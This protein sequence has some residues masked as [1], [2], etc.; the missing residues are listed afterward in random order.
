M[1]LLLHNK[2]YFVLKMNL[3]TGFYILLATLSLTGLF[4]CLGSDETEYIYSTDAQLTSFSLSHDSLAVLAKAKFSIDQK[5]SL[6]YNYDSLPY[7]TDTAAIASQAIVKYTAGSGSSPSLRIKHL[8]GDTAWVASGDTLRFAS[9]FEIKLYSPSGN[10]KTYTVSISIH[11]L[12]PD[13]VQ[14]RRVYISDIPAVTTPDWPTLSQHCPDTLKVVAC[15]GFLRPDEQKDLTLIVKDKNDLRFAFSKN[16]V[17]YQLGEKIPEGFPI[18]GFT[19]FNDRSFAGRLTVISSM[20][21]VW[22]TENGLYWT[23]LFGTQGLLPVIE[24]GNAFFYNNEIWFVN[25]KTASGEYNSKIYFSRDG[26]IVW[27]EKPEKTLP[28]VEFPL[29]QDATLVV[30]AEGKYYYIAGGRNQSGALNDVWKIAL[31]SRLFD[32]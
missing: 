2:N 22:A 17:D 6:I 24:G 5:K 14:Y 20:Q 28:P 1:F 19:I 29:R 18:T 4:S 12:D 13:S 23:N 11:Q 32:H 3:R 15:L 9:R 27:K 26:G 16:L 7:L 30:D 10:S 31:N 21:S 8:N 25:G